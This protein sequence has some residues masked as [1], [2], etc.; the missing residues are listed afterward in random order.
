MTRLPNQDFDSS[1]R[2]V[3]GAW[4]KLQGR[5]LTIMEAPDSIDQLHL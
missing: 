2:H 1:D 4:D 5:I 3:Q